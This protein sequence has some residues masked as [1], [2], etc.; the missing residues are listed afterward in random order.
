M[1]RGSPTA[2]S[3]TEDVMEGSSSARLAL[4]ILRRLAARNEPV[5][6]DLLESFFAG[7]SAL[8]LW[9]QLLNAIV[10]GSF[11]QPHVPVALNLT[12]IDP[13]VA[14]WL[15]WRKL[16][17]RKVNLSSPVE[18]VGGLA[19]MLLGWL[20]TAVVPSIW[21]WVLWGTVSGM[22]VGAVLVFTRRRHPMKADGQIHTGLLRDL[23]AA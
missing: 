20:V 7:R 18:G 21:W 3:L 10:R 6:G 11:R 8:W 1:E 19:L 4:W 23:F 5:A 9:W 14:E 15:T 12:P 17:P 16:G 13:I 2:K 22:V